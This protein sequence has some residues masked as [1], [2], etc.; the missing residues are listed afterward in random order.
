MTCHQGDVCK[1]LWLVKDGERIVAR[2]L[3]YVDDVV[4]TGP[5]NIVVKVLEMFKELWECK[6]SG[7]L[8]REDQPDKEWTDGIERVAKLNFLG[9]TLE[10][11]QKLVLHKHQYILTKLRDRNLLEGHG[12]GI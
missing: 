8:P 10:K 6:I 9:I 5:T 12:N 3:V 1:H 2:F 7:I 11:N 4:V